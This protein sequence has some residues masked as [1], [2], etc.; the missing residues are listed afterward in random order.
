MIGQFINFDHTSL[1]AILNYHRVRDEKKRKVI[2]AMEWCR[3][4]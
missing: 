4:W 2:K 3:F 1:V